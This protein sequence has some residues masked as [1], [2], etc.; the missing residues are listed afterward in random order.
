MSEQYGLNW[1]QI[2]FERWQIHLPKTKNGDPR[3][4]PLNSIAVAALKELRGRGGRM[5]K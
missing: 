1:S 2:D 3:T 4:I 5:K